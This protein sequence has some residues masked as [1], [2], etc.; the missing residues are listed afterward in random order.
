MNEKIIKEVSN[1]SETLATRWQRLW[2]SIIDS[3]TM[4]VITL[5]IMYF[6]GAFDRL[7]AGEQPGLIYNLMIALAGIGFFLLI[8]YKSLLNNGQT[9][10]KKLLGI[11]IVD[12]NATIPTSKNLL[13]RYAA[14]FGFGQVPIAGPIINLINILFIFGKEKRCGH[15]YIAGTKVI[16]ADD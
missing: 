8:N 1:Q 9:I 13:T 12:L 4:M 15:D 11:K 5:P 6:T 16:K 14:Y 7:A 3:L 10:G 2:A